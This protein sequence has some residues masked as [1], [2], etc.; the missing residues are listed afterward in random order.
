VPRTGERSAPASVHALATAAP[1][2]ATADLTPGP[3]GYAYGALA[4]AATARGWQVRTEERSFV[5][6]RLRWRAMVLAPVAGNGWNGMV[7]GTNGQG[8]T[9]EGALAVALA[10]MLARAERLPVE[11]FAPV[12]PARPATAPP[13]D[14]D[15]TPA[16]QAVAN[17]E[18]D[19]ASGEDNAS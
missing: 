1:I 8:P 13:P 19:L 7:S 17:Q 11:D 9:E 15:L 18:R 14:S 12:T 16:D 2:L 5:A 3:A 10:R 6:P 4:A